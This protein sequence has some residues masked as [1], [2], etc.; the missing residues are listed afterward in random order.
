MT[1]RI[2]AHFDGKVIV[3]E[4]AVNLPVG[5]SITLTYE[6]S[7]EAP[8]NDEWRTMSIDERLRRLDAAA[9]KF[10]FPPIPDEA[11]RRENMYDD[12]A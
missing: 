10:S 11:L 12:R 6:Q 2:R 1:Q 4:E 5:K 3:P 7:T 9:G 8:T